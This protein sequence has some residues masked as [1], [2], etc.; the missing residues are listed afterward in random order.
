MG[1]A[2]AR[3][4]VTNPNAQIHHLTINQA[5]NL[6]TQEQVQDAVEPL[7][8]EDHCSDVELYLLATGH[9]LTAMTARTWSSTFRAPVN[10]LSS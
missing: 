2:N 8:T 5:R 3:I 4:A 6:Y 1:L 7:P 9:R 10:V